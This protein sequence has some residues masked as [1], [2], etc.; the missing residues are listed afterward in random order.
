M[1]DNH[2]NSHPESELKAIF[3]DLKKALLRPKGPKISRSKYNWRIKRIQKRIGIFSKLLGIP[4]SEPDAV[5]S[6]VF[7][8]EGFNP[9]AVNPD[10]VGPAMVDPDVVDPNTAN[11][12]AANPTFV[13]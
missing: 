11:P 13:H 8:P 2:V 7:N 12:N 5:S 6:D 10:A 3:D 4:E 9:D 1:H